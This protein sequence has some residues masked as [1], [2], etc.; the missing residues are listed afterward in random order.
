MSTHNICYLQEIRKIAVFS[1]KKVPY[2]L[3]WEDHSA[4]CIAGLCKLICVRS[5]LTIMSNS[6]SMYTQ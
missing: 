3:L 6:E 5:L 4:Y 1:M 2:L